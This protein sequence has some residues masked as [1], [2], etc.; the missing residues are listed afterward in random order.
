[1]KGLWH[2]ANHATARCGQAGV[3]D[4]D[5]HAGR[6]EVSAPHGLKTWPK[7]F[8]AVMAGVKTFE[9][10]KDDR[11]FAVGDTLRLEEWDP[12]TGEYTGSL[13]LKHVTYVLPGGQ[14]GIEPGYVVL[15]LGDHP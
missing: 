4:G 14:F 3:P 13:L 6:S 12:E 11:G 15:G 2:F 1:M 10:R 7:F 8:G 5:D 9:V